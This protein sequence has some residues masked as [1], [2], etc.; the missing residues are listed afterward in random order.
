MSA[1]T[2]VRAIERSSEELAA[3]LDGKLG[4]SLR[5]DRAQCFA[6]EGYAQRGL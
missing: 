1:L 6:I 3:E 4:R 2:L 5:V